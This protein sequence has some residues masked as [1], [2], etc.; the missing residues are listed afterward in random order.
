MLREKWFYSYIASVLNED[1][2]VIICEIVCLPVQVYS[3]VCE[4][5]Y[6]HIIGIHSQSIAFQARTRPLAIIFRNW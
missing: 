3:C 6:V 2:S 4:C 1:L 5:L